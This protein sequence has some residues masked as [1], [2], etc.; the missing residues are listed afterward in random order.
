MRVYYLFINTRHRGT[1]ATLWSSL[2]R[3]IFGYLTSLWP[4]LGGQVTSALRWGSSAHT[5]RHSQF[6]SLTSPLHE[7][8]YMQFWCTWMHRFSRNRFWHFTS[9]MNGFSS[10][11][12]CFI[13]VNNTI[14]IITD[15]EAWFWWSIFCHHCCFLTLKSLFWEKSKCARVELSWL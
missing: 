2:L 8:L 12:K 11:L 6:F 4:H 10:C 5:L 13:W 15:Q 7:D 1:S 9:L 14:R 3:A